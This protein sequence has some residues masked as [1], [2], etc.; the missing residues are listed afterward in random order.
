[1]DFS[2]FDLVPVPVLVLDENYRLLFVNRRAREVYGSGGDTCYTLTHG[3]ESR[4]S[5][6][7]GHPCPIDFIREEKLPTYG[8]VHVHRTEDGDAYFYVLASYLEEDKLFLVIHL[9]LTDLIRSLEISEPRTELLMS[10]GPIV[11]FLRE[12]DEDWSVKFVSPNVADTFGYTAQDFTSGRVSYSEIVHPE[13]LPRVM[14]E[15]ERYSKA[16]APSWTHEDYR[17]ITR[18]GK[19]K[20]VLDHTVPVFDEEM[21]VTH[22]YSYVIDITEKHEQEELFRKLAESNPNGVILFDFSKKRIIYANRVLSEITGYTEEELRSIKDP[23]KLIHPKDRHV[24]L[25]HI[26]R[27]IEGDRETF[28]YNVRFLTKEGKNRWMKIISTVITYRGEECTLVT[29]IDITGEKSR[30]KR[31]HDL[32]THD[33]LTRIYNRRALVMFLDKYVHSA[34]RYGAPFSVILIDLDD[35]KKVNDTHGHQAGDRVLRLMSRMVRRML[36]RTDVFGRWGGEEFLIILPF[37]E[38]PYPVA[39]KV[40]KRLECTEFGSV[41]RVTASFGATSYRKG[42]TI[43]S[44]VARADRALYEAKRRGKNT[45]VYV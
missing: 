38:D 44:M 1:M 25:N 10:S 29:L 33:Q 24:V 5:A 26:R 9:D 15:V 19:I 45:V 36:R 31:L 3:S 7:E 39:E 14:D 4:C 42:D 28:S 23:L 27:R 18:D 34:R 6:Q 12:K 30:E 40:R 2:S 41:G 11:F 13:D 17:V 35:F 20:W 32:A 16:K 22:Y 21:N 43:D 8:T 37:N